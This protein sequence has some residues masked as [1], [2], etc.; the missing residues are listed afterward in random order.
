MRRLLTKWFCDFVKEELVDGSVLWID[1]H[2]QLVYVQP[3]SRRVISM[4]RTCDTKFS[5][6]SQEV[7]PT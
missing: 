4:R 2:D 6:K 5:T 3:V 7:A 1:P